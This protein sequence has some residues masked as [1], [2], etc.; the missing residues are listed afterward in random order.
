M[1]D[2]STT[3]RPG[4]SGILG[5]AFLLAAVITLLASAAG[6]DA[7]PCPSAAGRCPRS[8]AVE[9]AIARAKAPARE[10]GPLVSVGTASISRPIPDGFLGVS[11]EYGTVSAY[12]G[13]SAGSANNVLGELVRNLAPGQTPILRIGGDSTD[14]SWWPTLGIKRPPG[15]RTTLSPTW[16]SQAQQ[17]VA[18][19]GARLILG[20]NL[21]ADDPALAAAEVHEFTTGLGAANIEAFEVGNEPQLYPSRP[22]YFTNSG[23][24]VFGRTPL[25]NLADYAGEF[26][27]FARVLGRVP[28]AGPSSGRSWLTQL[29][30]FIKSKPGIRLVTYHA[31]RGRPQR[32]RLP[33]ARLRD[34]ARR[35]CLPNGQGSARAD[36]IAGHDGGT[37]A[38][39]RARAQVPAPLPGR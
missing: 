17:L 34:N 30:T 13:G 9:G 15:T 39:R 14:W 24:P 25:F 23:K 10:H 7:A 20:V 22:W 8:V 11:L 1:A 26:R 27:R 5:P 21:E 32:R 28:L 37:R 16:I 6:A 4:R 12:E 36:R 2:A 3:S 33:R 31:Y 29:G 19:T 18:T 35:A 38:G